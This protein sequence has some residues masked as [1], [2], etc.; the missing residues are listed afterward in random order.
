MN[1]KLCRNR[2]DIWEI[3]IFFFLH[4]F[5]DKVERRVSNIRPVAFLRLANG[6]SRMSFNRCRKNRVN[7]MVLAARLPSGRFINFYL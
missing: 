3:S 5:F 6:K 1:K 4:I 2:T 7:N